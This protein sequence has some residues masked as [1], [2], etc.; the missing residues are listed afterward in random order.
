V[1]ADF[2]IALHEAF[3]RRAA[4]MSTPPVDH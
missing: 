4:A 2:R 1:L 3:I